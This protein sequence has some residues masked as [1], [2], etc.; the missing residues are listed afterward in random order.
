MSKKKLG[1]KISDLLSSPVTLSISPR[2]S[3]TLS[4]TSDLTTPSNEYHHN[5]QTE[6]NSVSSTVPINE[7]NNHLS[8]YEQLMRTPSIYRSHD[9]SLLPIVNG[10]YP[11]IQTDSL[12]KDR[13]SCKLISI[14]TFYGNS[15]AKLN[16]QFLL[17]F[18][19]CFFL[20][21]SIISDV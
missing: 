14:L 16:S 15:H 2:T 10:T 18:F 7:S 20:K 9:Y 6:S 1:F 8:S 11:W 21:Y 17:F 13:F 4:T 12:L 5:R 3:S 19:G